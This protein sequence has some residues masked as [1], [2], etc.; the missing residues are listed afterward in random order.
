[1]QTHPSLGLPRT[2]HRFRV[3][4]VLCAIAA[5]LGV[6]AVAQQAG[7]RCSFSIPA[8]AAESALKVFSEQSGKGVIMNA[9]TVDGIRTNRLKGAFTPLEALQRLL[10]GTGLIATPDE[11]SGAFVVHRESAPPSDRLP[12]PATPGDHARKTELRNHQP[13]NR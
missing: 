3:Q 9:D 8:Q 1:M 10:A 4:A 2:Q 13:E 7:T 6:P 12:P 11:K 5:L